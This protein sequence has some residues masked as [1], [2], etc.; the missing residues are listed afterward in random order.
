M[1]R[2][3]VLHPSN[4]PLDGVGRV[5][6]EYR[7]ARGWDAGLGLTGPDLDRVGTVVHTVTDVANTG[8]RVWYRGSVPNGSIDRDV[9]IDTVGLV[10]NVAHDDPS[11]VSALVEVSVSPRAWIDIEQRDYTVHDSGAELPTVTT[12][13]PCFD[14]ITAHSI[15]TVTSSAFAAAATGLGGDGAPGTQIALTW[16]VDGV[17]LSAVSGQTVVAGSSGQLTYTLANDELTLTSAPGQRVRADVQATVTDGAATAMARTTFAA[18]GIRGWLSDEDGEKVRA[19]KRRFSR[20]VRIRVPWLRVPIP[21]PPP[22]DTLVNPALELENWERTVRVQFAELPG[23]S[24][25]DRAALGQ[26]VELQRLAAQPAVL[27]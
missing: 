7:A 5:Y 6:V 18:D 23:L 27:A 9:V 21:D 14:V 16:S 26:L 12:S 25:T 24:E 10:V 17:P 11:G 20:W 15:N 4:E 2:V 1:P 8:P 13:T 19:C 22:F 3:L